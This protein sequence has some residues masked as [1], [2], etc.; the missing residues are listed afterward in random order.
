MK[1]KIAANVDAGEANGQLYFIF[2]NSR[3]ELVIEADPITVKLIALMDGTKSVNELADAVGNEVNESEI[4]ELVEFLRE[5]RI[6]TDACVGQALPK[7][8]SDFERQ[9]EFFADFTDNPIVIQQR[10]RD[11]RVGILGL[12]TIGGMITAQ[13]CRMGVGSI[14]AKDPDTV[15]ASNLPRH[16]LFTAKD[17]GKTKVDSTECSLKAVRPD[18]D[19]RGD[20]DDVCGEGDLAAFAANCDLLVNCADQPSVAQTSEWVGNACMKTETPHILAGGYRT[21]LG[22]LGP[23]ITPFKTACWK[24]FADDYAVNDPF[25]KLGWQPLV[26]SRVSGGSLMPMAGMVA[27]THAWEA[28]R[29]LTGLLPPMMANRK[30]ELDYI[31]FG[32]KFYEVNRNPGCSVCGEAWSLQ[33]TGRV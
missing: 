23:T 31:T 16:A 21:H 14:W 2:V 8:M 9:I 18:L 17:I 20:T 26:A 28:F 29:V 30:A 1:P 15:C 3:E 5:Q 24:C 12:G 13:L 25:G 22:F 6:V 10:I 7:S 4:S 19:F 32:L 33:N 27:S 11:S